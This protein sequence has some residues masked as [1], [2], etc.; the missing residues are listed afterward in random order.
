MAEYIRYDAGLQLAICR[1]CQSGIAP[2]APTRHF[3]KHHK[4]TWSANRAKIV[5][6]IQTLVLAT[7][8]DIFRVSQE[9]TVRD[10]IEGLEIKSGWC[11][12]EDECCYCSVSEKVLENHCRSVH[13]KEAMER[14]GW[15]ETRMQTLLGNPNIW[16]LPS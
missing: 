8:E 7:T 14:R 10:P 9:V 11:C 5:G 16:Y 6:Y 2:A 12:G 3:R 13:G 1:A 15:F 4:E